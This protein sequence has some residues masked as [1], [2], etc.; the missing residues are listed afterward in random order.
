[1]SQAKRHAH[2][3]RRT[4]TTFG[5]VWSC[6][7]P[8]CNHYMPRHMESMLPGKNAQCNECENI[9][10]LTHEK[11]KSDEPICDECMVER[12]LRLRSLREKAVSSNQDKPVDYD[13]LIKGIR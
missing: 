5:R 11:M 9:Y 2:R 13:A 10:I 4:Y 6:S 3:Y 8:D 1:M 7:L 12:E